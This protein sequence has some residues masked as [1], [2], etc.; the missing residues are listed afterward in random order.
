LKDAK[1]IAKETVNEI[2]NEFIGEIV[3]NTVEKLLDYVINAIRIDLLDKERSVIVK[4]FI[5]GN[6]SDCT[7]EQD[8]VLFAEEY[9][10]NYYF[11]GAIA[12]KP[13]TNI[14]DIEM[15]LRLRNSLM[16][17]EFLYLEDI[18]EI[19]ENEISMYRGFGK[20][21][22]YDLKI[23]LEKHNLKFKIYF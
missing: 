13:K 4:S 21:Q 1:L 8:I 20:K 3:Q 10:N 11:T 5:K 18:V 22:M 23:L 14:R 2:E 17:H 12:N 7:T 9:Y 6:S 15:S 16:K 19:G